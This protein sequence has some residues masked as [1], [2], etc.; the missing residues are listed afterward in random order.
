[1]SSEPSEARGGALPLLAFFL[2]VVGSCEV[3]SGAANLGSHTYAPVPEETAPELA[4]HLRELDRL[5]A[6]DPHRGPIAA[7]TVVVGLML[8][9]GSILLARRSPNAIWWA[10][11][12][13]IAN[14]L[15]AAGSLASTYL[16]F[17]AIGGE[18]FRELQG[19]T[20]TAPSGPSA[21]QRMDQLWIGE[22]V[23]RGA[24]ILVFAY[25]LWRATRPD[26]QE[27]LD[28]RPA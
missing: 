25:M 11:Q 8:C 13:L 23:T 12:A 4:E 3:Y 15:L 5:R 9:F 7:S 6:D 22:G 17:H 26:V 24:M 2:M 18:L 20:L 27:A 28:E 10:K 16:H 21:V 19:V 1:M 14:I